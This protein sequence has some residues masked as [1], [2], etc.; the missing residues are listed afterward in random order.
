MQDWGSEQDILLK[1]SALS[2]LGFLGREDGSQQFFGHATRLLVFIF[3]SYEQAAMKK[4]DCMFVKVYDQFI[5]VGK[6]I[7]NMAS[8]KL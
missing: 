4:Q 2:L 6:V 1:K 8:I 3:C 5:F 7:D